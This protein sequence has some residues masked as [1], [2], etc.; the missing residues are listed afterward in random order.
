MYPVCYVRRSVISC[1]FKRKLPLL[2]VFV[3]A[4]LTQLAKPFHLA[5]D[6]CKVSIVLVEKIFFA[7]KVTCIFMSTFLLAIHDFARLQVGLNM[8]HV[9]LYFVFND[10]SCYLLNVIVLDENCNE[11]KDEALS[12]SKRTR[13]AVDVTSP[14]LMSQRLPL[15]PRKDYNLSSP[16]HQPHDCS[17]APN[18]LPKTSSQDVV[19]TL[20]RTRRNLA[21]SFASLTSDSSSALQQRCNSV[22]EIRDKTHSYKVTNGQSKLTGDKATVVSAVTSTTPSKSRKKVVTPSKTVSEPT[23]LATAPSKTA[24]ISK[25][26]LATMRLIKDGGMLLNFCHLYLFAVKIFASTDSFKIVLQI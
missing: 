21:S 11:S 18:T 23:R 9:M 15:S 5:K 16:V 25:H 20:R 1:L 17:S 14:S 4:R 26:E 24:G 13:S 8:I 6:P 19:Q 12:P 2:T 7:I 22:D 10:F 3:K